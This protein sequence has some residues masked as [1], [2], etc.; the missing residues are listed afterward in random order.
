MNTIYKKNA[1]R[2]LPAGAV[3][4]KYEERYLGLA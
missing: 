2:F 4:F 1:R 3:Y